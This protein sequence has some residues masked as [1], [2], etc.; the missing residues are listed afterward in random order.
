VRSSHSRATYI[1][2]AEDPSQKLPLIP[3]EPQ[4]I[5]QQGEKGALSNAPTEFV[6]LLVTIDI[7]IS[8]ELARNKIAHIGA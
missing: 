3:S 7:Y 1:E 8:S 4:G 2:S 5:Q 6:L